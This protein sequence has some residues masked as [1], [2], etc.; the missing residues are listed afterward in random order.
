MFVQ[1]VR[2]LLSTMIIDSHYI[3]GIFAMKSGK[4]LFHIA[5]ADVNPCELYT[6]ASSDPQAV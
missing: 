5:T 1:W 6:E 2:C 3:Y 4:H